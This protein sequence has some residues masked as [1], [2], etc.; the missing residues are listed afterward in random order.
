MNS[1]KTYSQPNELLKFLLEF[2]KEVLQG[3]NPNVRLLYE[4]F[5]DLPGGK[6]RVFM[7]LASVRAS[8]LGI[9]EDKSYC[10]VPQELRKLHPDGAL[11]VAELSRIVGLTTTS[12][13]E[14]LKDLIEKG[15][16]ERIRTRRRKPKYRY[17]TLE[18]IAREL[19]EEGFGPLLILYARFTLYKTIVE[20]HKDVLINLFF[21]TQKQ[22]RE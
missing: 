9:I 6:Y 14:D 1:S 21:P 7:T 5:I 13:Y 12:T 16:V 10:D 11:G 17:R 15:Y 2:G 22:H 18:D 8:E 4:I 19:V 20:N 3:E